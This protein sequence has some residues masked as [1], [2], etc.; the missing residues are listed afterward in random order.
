MPCV[1]LAVLLQTVSREKV[2]ISPLH[3]ELKVLLGAYP[4]LESLAQR[5]VE[6]PGS[7]VQNLDSAFLTL[8]VDDDYLLLP[9]VNY[10]SECPFGHSIKHKNSPLLDNPYI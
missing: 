5:V 4:L 1:L 8:S 2:E 9:K 3:P 10:I 6:Q 7:L